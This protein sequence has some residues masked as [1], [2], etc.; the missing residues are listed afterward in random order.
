MMDGLPQGILPHG[1]PPRQR[2]V[3]SRIGCVGVGLHG[4]RRV[5]MTICPGPVDRGVVFQRIDLPNAP[6]LPARWDCVGDTRLCTV[7]TDLA[8]PA[9]RVGTVE[10]LMA[11]LATVGVT[12]AVIEIDGAECPILDGSAAPFVFLLDCAGVVEQDATVAVVMPTRPIRVAQGAAFA[13]L[14]P[15]L[16]VGALALRMSIEFDA[17]AIGR[18]SVAIGAAEPNLRSE[19]V[20]ART[21]TLAGEI[22]GL[23]EAG[24]ARG[25]SL[26]NAVVVDGDRVLNPGGWRMDD[27]CARHKLLD[28]VGDLA[29]A[30]VALRGRFT[31]HCSGHTLN[32]QLLRAVFADR[33]NWRTVDTAAVVTSESGWRG[34]PERVAA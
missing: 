26:D 13:E 3:R 9:T 8:D 10:H 23:R 33:A 5:A 19:L 7:L 34:A 25:G 17:G 4:G 20:W 16:E 6:V 18:Q 31:G 30:G 28:A 15:T 1:L 27:E 32:N 22:A 14:R 11:A 29:L 24:L 2:T 12:N 21:F